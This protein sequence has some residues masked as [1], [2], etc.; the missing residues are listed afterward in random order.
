MSSIDVLQ[1]YTV[2]LVVRHF[3]PYRDNTSWS[4]WTIRPRWQTST[5]KEEYTPVNFT[6]YGAAI[7]GLSEVHL[8]GRLNRDA[9]L[10]SRGNPLPGVWRF[11]PEIV[12]VMWG[13]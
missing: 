2:L 3:H 5:T 12:E 10:L 8:P 1:P 9:D 6:C 4:S 13:R 7:R 11:H